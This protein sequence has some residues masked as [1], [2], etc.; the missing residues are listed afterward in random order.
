M[1][2]P[3]YSLT[4]EYFVDGERATGTWSS[5]IIEKLADITTGLKLSLVF[6]KVG[7]KLPVKPTL[8]SYIKLSVPFP[9]A[10]S[11]LRKGE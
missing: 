3:L 8:L 4:N 6:G 1:Y 10:R 7:C 5:F 2:K 11:P 9:S